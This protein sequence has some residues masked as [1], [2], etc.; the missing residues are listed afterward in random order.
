ME[1]QSNDDESSYKF[2]QERIIQLAEWSFEKNPKSVA[3]EYEKLRSKKT[4]Y[5]LDCGSKGNGVEYLS[6]KLNLNLFQKD[7]FVLETPSPRS[8]SEK[9]LARRPDRLYRFRVAFLFSRDYKESSLIRNALNSKNFSNDALIIV[10][11]SSTPFNLFGYEKFIKY[12]G[13]NAFCKGFN[14][15]FDDRYLIQAEKVV[16]DWINEAINGLNSVCYLDNKYSVS[17]VEEIKNALKE[18][19]SLRFPN[20]FDSEIEDQLNSSSF[21][22]YSKSE[23]SFKVGATFEPDGVFS[24]Q[25]LEKVFSEQMF[26]INFG[27][28]WKGEDSRLSRIRLKL[29]KLIE[30]RIQK[31]RSRQS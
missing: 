21:I 24:K 18:I 29:D 15:K 22:N 17:S 3:I 25:T 11:L 5:Y 4:S 23:V 28:D 31:K 14:T 7:R 27:M 10:D 19:Q 16:D 12:A 20:L 6:D 2:T 13:K 8:F 26:F 9:S 30:E 1:R